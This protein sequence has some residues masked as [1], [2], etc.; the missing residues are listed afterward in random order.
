MWMRDVE[1]TLVV[2]G[3]PVVTLE[4]KAKLTN[5]VRVLFSQIGEIV[6]LE[7][8]PRDQL[9]G[10]VTDGYAIIGY[11]SAGEVA[12]AYEKVNG[13][14]LAKA[15]TFVVFPMLHVAYTQQLRRCFR[16]LVRAA[17]V[18][19]SFHRRRALR[20]RQEYVAMDSMGA[21]P[22][23]VQQQQ[24]EHELARL[25]LEHQRLHQRL[26]EKDDLLHQLVDEHERE[27]AGK[28]AQIVAME[29]RLAPVERQDKSKVAAL[30]TSRLEELEAQAIAL[31]GSVH[32]NLEVLREE[33]ITRREEDQ[34][35][36]LCMDQLRS[37][38]FACG[39]YNTCRGC[40]D[41]VEECP[42]CRTRITQRLIIYR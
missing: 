26:T 33:L 7:L 5:V 25:K 1:R 23:S 8:P 36:I 3:L 10:D 39:H 35:C 15:H 4:K 12:D 14:A 2:T 41:T 22:P 27:L 11:G 17:V 28:D 21:R 20:T 40:S 19:L 13:F 24:L 32:H 18:L 29:A 37:V 9:P 38:A 31:Q 42:V 16:G 34:H 6:R 30:P